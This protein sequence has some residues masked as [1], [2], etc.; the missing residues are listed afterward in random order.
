MKKI[1][2]GAA[3]AMAAAVG[4]SSCSQAGGSLENQKNYADS[5]SYVIGSA[6][7]DYFLKTIETIPSPDK[8]KFSKDDFLRGVKEVL[9]ADTNKVGYF[10]GIQ[11]AIQLNQN[12]VAM[13]RSGV[14]VDRALLYKQFAAAFSA[15]S[16]S[17]EQVEKNNELLGNL[18]NQARVKMMEKQRADQEKA[19]AEMKAK[20]DENENAGKAYIE[21]LKSK[22]NTIKTTES[23]LSYKVEQQ[24]QG[25]TPTEND[26]VMVKYTGKLIDGTVFD[27]SNEPVPMNINRVIRGFSEGL[28]MMNK[29]SKYTLYIP[30]DLAYGMQGTPDGS[31]PPMATLIFEVEVADIEP[32]N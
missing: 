7:G 21:N 26:N 29:G 22:D 15:D 30:G 32:A 2:L 1:F 27:S 4:M 20:A 8:E 23:G 18:M 28:K 10:Y 24:G 5:L 17:D 9:M 6:Q 16:V 25:A 3:V 14:D 19:R 12:L 13:S 11:I 31:I